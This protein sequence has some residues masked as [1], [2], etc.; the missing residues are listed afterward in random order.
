[1]PSFQRAS[2]M[3]I[4]KDHLGNEYEAPYSFLWEDV[5]TLET[6]PR[7]LKS[8]KNPCAKVRVLLGNGLRFW[9]LGDAEKWNKRWDRYL[10]AQEEAT[11]RFHV[12]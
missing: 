2:A 11:R 1:M 9:I 10:N 4:W 7:P 6:A 5:Y 8:W 12:N 3:R